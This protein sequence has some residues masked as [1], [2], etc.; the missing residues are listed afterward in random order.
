MGSARGIP[1]SLSPP[2]QSDPQKCMV[3]ALPWSTEEELSASHSSSVWQGFEQALGLFV[4]KTSTK[5]ANQEAQ[6]RLL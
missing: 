4:W 1:G 2:S 5:P 3:S 6:A